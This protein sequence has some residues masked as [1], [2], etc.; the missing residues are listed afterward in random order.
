VVFLGL[1]DKARG[2]AAVLSVV[3]VMKNAEVCR[4]ALPADVLLVDLVACA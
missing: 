2:G 1:S 4:A 3:D